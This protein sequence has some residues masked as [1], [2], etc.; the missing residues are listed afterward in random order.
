MQSHSSILSTTLNTV[1]EH[2]QSNSDFFDS[3]AI[4]PLPSYPGREQEGLLN[5]LLAKKLTPEVAE[6]ADEGRKVG[7]AAVGGMR[8]DVQQW[9]ELWEWAAIEGNDHSKAH[10]WFSDSD[11]DGE[12]E[13][14]ADGDEARNAEMME[15][16]EE[17]KVKTAGPLG[18]EQWMKFMTRGEMPPIKTGSRPR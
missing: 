11:E 8:S 9:K 4:Y 7:E 17:E 18:S 16:V 2:L 15:G 14:E 3:T 6:W 12:G 1:T 13:N 5:Q 10:D